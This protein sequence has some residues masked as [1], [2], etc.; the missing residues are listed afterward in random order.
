MTSDRFIIFTVYPWFQKL[1][2]YHGFTIQATTA[3]PDLW[4]GYH[5][6]IKGFDHYNYLLD[7]NRCFSRWPARDI[8]DRTR[9]IKMPFRIGSTEAWVPPNDHGATLTDCLVTRAKMIDQDYDCVNIMWSGGIDSTAMLVAFLQLPQRRSNLRVFYMIDSIKE[10]PGFF[11]RLSQMQEIEMIEIGGRVWLEGNFQGCTVGAG[12]CDDLTASLDKS[13]FDKL[14]YRGLQ[15]NWKDYFWNCNPDA[16]FL[17]FCEHYF[18]LSGRP[19]DSLLEARWWFYFSCKLY[20][21]QIQFNRDPV[22]DP[23]IDFYYDPL[24]IAYFYHN[25]HRLIESDRFECYKLELKEFIHAFYPDNHYLKYKEKYNSGN[26]VAL[27]RKR[28]ILQD[29]RAIMILDDNTVISTPNLPFL[30]EKDYR[31]KYHRSLDILFNT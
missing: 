19:I 1:L 23:T 28:N 10:N 6:K 17:E 21:R 8:F 14:G 5:H 11:L 18:R 9:S 29:S 25:T 26:L 31:S 22:H 12:V 24:L 2:T 7:I 15:A 4:G 13:F 30:R 27:D 16:D 20:E 3:K